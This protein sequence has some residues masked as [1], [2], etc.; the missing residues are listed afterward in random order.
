MKP[1]HLKL[2]LVL[3]LAQTLACTRHEEHA[4]AHETHA[5]PA[6]PGSDEHQ[7]HEGHTGH[8]GH[9]AMPA[10]RPAGDTSLYQLTSQFTDQSDQPFTF[11][12]LTGHPTLV[13]MFYGSCETICPTLLEDVR[14]I[15]NAVAADK[16]AGLR[17][18]LVTFDP[19][20]DTAQRL[21]AMAAEK[22]FDLTR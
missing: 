6:T 4:G 12:S 16:R 3:S 14:A 2:V 1:T 20:R 8:E 5:S 9:M 21:T 17:V 7:G 13:L 22:H 18:L 10:A 19:E 11:S 15:D